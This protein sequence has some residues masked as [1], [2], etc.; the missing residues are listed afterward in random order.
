[1]RIL[2]ATSI[3]G[4]SGK[5]YPIKIYPADMRFNDFIAGIYILYAGNK[6]LFAGHS[7][8]VDFVLQKSEAATKLADKGLSSIGLIR[9]GSPV[10]RQSILDD[11]QAELSAELTEI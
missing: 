2:E 1:M 4:Q 6:A 11:L 5:S 3:E 10:K 7:E 8:N 9:M